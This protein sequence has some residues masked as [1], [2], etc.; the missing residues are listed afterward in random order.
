MEINGILISGGFSVDYSDNSV[1][2]IDISTSSGS[3]FTDPE[4]VQ[5]FIEEDN[6]EYPD[7]ISYQIY[8]PT[9][10]YRS[11]ALAI[12]YSDANQNG[13]T[14]SIGWA[15][16]FLATAGV[17]SDTDPPATIVETPTL[18]CF[19]L[20]TLIETAMG[21]VAVEQLNIGDKVLSH[22][23]REVE[24][25]WIGW[26]KM[27]GAF[28]AMMDGLPVCISVGALGNGLPV[29]DIFVSPDHALYLV[30]CMLV[31]A[32]A[33]VNGVT[34]YQ[35][36]EWEGDVTYFHIETEKHEIIFAEGAPT[37]TFI[38]NVSRKAFNNHAEYEALYPNAKPMVE[39]DIPR[40]KYA[41]QV[42][43][44]MLAKLDFCSKVKMQ[45]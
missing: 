33:L 19:L 8:T 43:K 22:S 10:D 30:D 17:Y 14:V 21:S 16:S 6:W 23:G 25:K 20:G 38:D 29:R 5:L 45:A 27:H 42:P 26:Q 1:V 35:V 41:R 44:T 2:G 11:N 24:V 36:I 31:H 18:Y 4:L 28:A 32:K 3:S 39:L 40:V 13:E 12:G 9:S 34:I 7:T 15:N 37:E